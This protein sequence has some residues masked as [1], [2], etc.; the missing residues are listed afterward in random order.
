MTATAL[1]DKA[2]H[3][4]R[5]IIITGTRSMGS[6]KISQNITITFASQQ[7]NPSL[8]DSVFAFR[9]PAGAKERKPP[10][11]GGTTPPR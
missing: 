3:L 6:E 5:Q 10:G 7:I 8:P 2:T 4:V 11:P 1:I 9:P